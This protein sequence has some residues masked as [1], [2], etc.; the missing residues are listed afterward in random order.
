MTGGPVYTSKGTTLI[1][2]PTLYQAFMKSIGFNPTEVSR[3]QELLYL[4]KING[5]VT[6]GTR[7][8]FN[9]RITNT[10]RRYLIAIREGD[11]E[12]QIEQQEKLA[13][14]L[15]DIV[16]FNYGL[17]LTKPGLIYTPDTWSL[18]KEAVKDISTEYRISQGSAYEIYSNLYDYQAAGY[19]LFSSPK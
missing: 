16:K 4:E 6:S 3:K 5:G 7:K 2:D 9:N 18:F 8:R 14:I 15:A 13:E 10:F 1:E 11:V 17:S 19:P 12:E